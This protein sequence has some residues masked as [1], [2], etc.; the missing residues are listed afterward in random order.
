MF[1]KKNYL[2]IYVFIFRERG[3][4][5]RNVSVWLPLPS[6]LLGTWSA[7]QACALTENPNG[8]LLLHTQAGT[9]S[10]EPHQ[11]GLSSG[12]YTETSSKNRTWERC[13]LSHVKQAEVGSL[14][15]FLFCR[16]WC[17]VAAEESRRLKGP[18]SLQR[19]VPWSPSFTFEHPSLTSLLALVLD[20]RNPLQAQ[21]APQINLPPSLAPPPPRWCA[22]ARDSA[23]AD[24]I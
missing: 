20:S 15:S 16:Q 14:D 3:R 22:L 8:N 24:F 17:L 18:P 9:Q 11:P 10:T 4:E 21:Q 13:F 7:T 6:P 5:E 1:F 23:E 12:L 19:P 2:F